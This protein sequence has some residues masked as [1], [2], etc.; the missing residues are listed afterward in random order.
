MERSSS[1]RT[2]RIVITGVLTAVAFMAV[3]IGKI[4]PNVAGFLSYDP[5]DA[6]IAISGFIYGPVTA[7]IITV[8]VSLVEMFTISTTGLYGLI[9]NIFS[10]ASFVLPAVLVYKSM[11]SMKGAFA[12]A[13]AG[14]VCMT[15]S[16]MLWNY[17]ITPFYMDVP[18]SMVA[19]MMLS[20]FMPF[21]LIKSGINAGIALLLY[22]PLVTALRKAK[23]I[24]AAKENKGINWKYMIVSAAILVVF[25]VAFVIM[26]KPKAKTEEPAAAE[27]TEVVEETSGAEQ[28]EEAAEA[29]AAN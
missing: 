19:G 6:V 5:K 20:V 25:V 7:L 3:L 12:G 24:P 23:L 29:P 10:T 8:L 14:I 15:V 11:R 16:M 28:G 27:Q 1:E 2:R 26:V 9:M 17:I 21:N 18:R 4:V 22:K 13:A